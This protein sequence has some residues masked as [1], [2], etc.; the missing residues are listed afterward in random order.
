MVWSLSCNASAGINATHFKT[1]SRAIDPFIFNF[2]LYNFSELK[3]RNCVEFTSF[4][5]KL[6]VFS[7]HCTHLCDSSFYC[8][9]TLIYLKL[10]KC[11]FSSFPRTGK[12]R[13]GYEVRVLLPLLII[14]MF[15]QYRFQHFHFSLS[16][17]SQFRSGSPGF[18][19]LILCNFGAYQV[20]YRGSQV[21]PENYPIA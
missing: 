12:P 14:V 6:Q 3:P 1:S 19:E 11:C 2:D 15:P 7:L 18:L 8:G 5:I 13:T 21:V 10:F 4:K 20:D 9:V 16:I 17:V